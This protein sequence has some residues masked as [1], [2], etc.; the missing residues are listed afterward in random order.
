MPFIVD[1]LPP[2]ADIEAASAL[3]LAMSERKSK[4]LLGRKQYEPIEVIARFALPLKTVTWTPGEST[5]RCLAFDP[6]GLVSGGIRFDL[7][8]Q[9]PETELDPETGEEAF[10]ALCQQWTKASMEFTPK[11]LEFVGLITQTDQVA[12]LLTGDDENIF[13]AELEQKADTDDALAQ[14]GA[15]LESYEKAA[16]AWTELKQKAYA[17]RDVL[18]VKIKEYAGEE[19][20][21]GAKSLEDLNSQ[22]ETAI[23]SKR[24]ETDAALTAAQED[25][26]KRRDML[27]LELD[28]FQQGFKEN[29]DNYWRDQIKAA[30]K[31]LA[32]TEKDLVKKRQEIE[33][34]FKD[35]E[36]QQHSKVQNF[37]IE[38]DKRIASFDTRLKRLDSALEGFNKGLEKRMALYAQQPG[39]V[40]TATVEISTERCAQTHKAVFH[41]VRYPGERWLVI[42]PQVIGS[43]GIMGT[44]S[45][46]F[47][48]LNLPFR[49]ASKLAETLADKMQKLLPGSE[50]ETRLVE[51]NLLQT[52]EFFPNAKVGL[53]KLIDQGKVDKKHANLFADL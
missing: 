28:R 42:P 3:G 15:Q 41:A 46:L 33:D 45:G 14:L 5:G 20:A 38:L 1:L 25:S 32:D 18:A 11:T 9:I 44:V 13:V 24:S 40:E 17:H 27:Q 2:S 36:K 51:A 12:Q 43:R 23:G 7:D 10:L 19:K 49:A 21:A 35:F 22:V 37:K 48:G 34:G 16:E 47:G 8:P 39:R 50:L 52:A 4:G 53:G 31:G 29:G 26:Q 30:E 6:Q